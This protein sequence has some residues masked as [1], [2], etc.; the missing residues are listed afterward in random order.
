MKL[1]NIAHSRMTGYGPSAV[2]I[3]SRAKAGLGEQR[4]ARLPLALFCTTPKD[5]CGSA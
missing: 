1:F 5:N 3:L 2:S 4:L